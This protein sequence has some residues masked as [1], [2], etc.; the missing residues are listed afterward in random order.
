MKM[1][2]YVPVASRAR[3]RAEKA[4][5]SM[6]SASG[7]IAGGLPEERFSYSGIQTRPSRT[8]SPVADRWNSARGN[9]VSSPALFITTVSR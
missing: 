5:C 1:T 3:E 2:G 9:R 8:I 7:P 4:R 6:R